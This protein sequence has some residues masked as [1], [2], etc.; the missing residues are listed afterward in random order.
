[1]NR[2]IRSEILKLTST[3][4]FKVTA[5][6][7][8]VLSPVSAVVNV[9]SNKGGP[10]LGSRAHIHHVLSSSALASM[11]MLATGIA[12]M[13][14]E[15]RH[16]TAVPTF[17][18]TPRRR[19]VVIAKLLTGSGIG[20]LLGAASFGLS[21]GAA[22]ISFHTKHLD[23]LA[24]DTAQMWVGAAVATG[25]YASLGIALG[26]LTRNV[27]AAI[28]AALV[29]VQLVEQAFLASVFPTIGKWMPTGANLAITH[30]AE[31]PDKLLSPVVAVGVLIGW[32]TVLSIAAC[33]FVVRRDL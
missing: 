29:W 2:L 10:P 18:V 21:L 3:T 1:M 25:A 5:L 24:G 31:N 7:I 8:L 15:H 33:H 20:L 28:L 27:V 22:V 16:N 4:W 11:A 6:V 13:A 30:T 32:T 12:L 14:G 9:F 17:L 19:D 26:A 23:H